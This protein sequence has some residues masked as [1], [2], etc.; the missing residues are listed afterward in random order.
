MA[1]ATKKII[2]PKCRKRVPKNR[3]KLNCTICDQIK[4]PS[5]QGLSKNDAEYIINTRLSWTCIDCITEILP[6][7]AC[8]KQKG[9][10]PLA[11]K[12][13][14]SS[15]NG[16]CYSSTNVR[17][18][19]HCNGS[20]HL[21]CYKNELGC[22][23]CCESIIPGYHVNLYELYDDFGRLNDSMF[24][25]YVRDHFTNII[26]DAISNEEHH[27]STWNEV[28]E[29]LINC[30][31]QQQKNV[32]KSGPT[33]L[34]I[35]SHNIRSLAK[36]ISK[37][38]DNNDLYDKYDILAF[39]ETNLRFEEVANGSLKFKSEKLPNGLSDL[40][41]QDFHGPI[42]QNP[43]S[44]K[45]GGLAIYVNKRVVELEA[46][47]EPFD[48]NP[49]STDFSGEF[50]FIKINKCKGFQQ[51][52]ILANI[53]RSPSR[54]AESFNLLLDSILYKL[55]RHSKK[56]IVIAG[57][58]NMDLLKYE[59][60]TDYQDLINIMANHGLVQII[61][62]PTRI[63]DTSATLLDHVYTNN[64]ENTLSSNIITI[65]LSDHLATLTTLTLDK[66]SYSTRINYQIANSL[67]VPEISNTRVFKEANNEKFKELIN[68]ES[69]ESVN[70]TDE[71]P[72]D[73]THFD[74]FLLVY[75][76]HYNNAYPLKSN[77]VRRKNE[78][79]NSK[80]W[81]LPWLEDA[82]SRKDDLFH[83]SVKFPTTENIDTYKKMS[84]FCEKHVDIAKERHT[85][86]YF[87]KYKDD[88][89]KQWQMINKLL[90]R[91]IYRN[92]QLRVKD[93]KGNILSKNIDVAERFNDYFSNIAANLK[94]STGNGSNEVFDPGGH[95]KYLGNSCVQNSMYLK[96]VR[97][98]EVHEVIKDFKNKASLDTKI[99]PLKLANES[100]SFT[101][102][103]A[104]LI[105][106]SF[107]QGIFPQSLKLA[108]VIPIYKE[109][110]KTDVENYRPISLLSSFSKIYE[111]LM[112]KRVLEFL[113]KNEALHEMQYGFRPGRSCEHALLNAQNF[114]LESLSKKQVTLLL[115]VDF[116]KAFDTIEHA[117]LLRKLEHYGIRGIVLKWFE[118]YLDQRK[119][120]VCI[121][122]SNSKTKP[123]KYGVPQGSILG[124]L[125]FIIYINDIPG[126]SKFA[127]FILYADDANIFITASTI[128]EVFQ[129]FDDLS[130]ELIQWV[131][132]N[133]LALNLKK[134]KYMIFST[135]TLESVR[136]IKI[137]NKN[138][139]R[140]SEARFLGVIIDE[141]LNWSRHIATI[142]TKMARYVGIM[143]KL[144]KRLPLK[145]RIQIFHS[146]VQSHLNFCSLLWGFSAK[147]N[148]ELLFR[149]QKKAMRAIMPGYV[150]YYYKD[151]KLPAH[152][153]TSFAEYEIVTVH[154]I[155]TSN[156]LLFMH[157]V[158]NFPQLLPLSI[159]KTIPENAPTFNSDDDSNID[160]FNKYG[161][162]KYK[163]TI[164]CKGPLL[165]I[166]QF[167]N[168]VTSPSSLL[169]IN[170]YKK[171]LKYMLLREQSKGE[172]DSWPN[173]IIHNTPGLR[174][175][176]RERK[177]TKFY[178]SG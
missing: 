8:K 70:I 27:N 111:K 46:Q 124:P 44:S 162:N 166:S 115:L 55:N 34:K 87:E 95:G 104:N 1:T 149:C 106:K 113:D 151:G 4:H 17:V 140:K 48:P 120:F 51:T 76:S 21:K 150:S 30:K 121:N 110:S 156:A 128:E 103:I 109:G 15:C 126:I 9:S 148:I 49:D 161:F 80:P 117:I 45:G 123:I 24:N 6:I 147:S 19:N 129:K 82:I 7:N 35:F 173:F 139:E 50:Q 22:T 171:N 153:K 57:D 65:D 175:G 59:S 160:W 37:L 118:S 172:P 2:C 53:Y 38:R 159:R 47:I 86:K 134:T 98:N 143:Y 105:N 81:I 54:K 16:Y 79:L 99:G 58:F 31:Y 122:G 68:N 62:R 12:V 163:S 141:K 136:D 108:K 127:H 176:C 131:N 174:A 29:L 165:A 13:Q 92:E 167:N 93:K 69:W 75:T 32:K 177:A 77:R 112:H 10:I 43:V 107:E 28:S 152:T 102:T 119:Q 144:K 67:R 164:F 25:P 63:T 64:L 133:G 66:N 23:K 158:R 132:S 73:Q 3:P 135:K 74:E 100:F 14:C 56:H 18:C 20:V 72:D 168:E 170:I 138:I 169:S 83:K 146:F 33:E 155:I 41:L 137:G 90:G 154:G 125:L 85:K 40:L 178:Q 94:A 36:N 61:S 97:S 130:S 157:K 89:K 114:I 96:P 91:K 42:L 11:F 88:S 116:S 71:N 78:R 5:C 60:T 39:N 84:K 145:A 26:G 52:K 142:K 101:E